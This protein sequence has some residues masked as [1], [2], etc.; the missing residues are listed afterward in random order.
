MPHWRAASYLIAHSST[1][2][3]NNTL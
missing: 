2:Y 1:N 3:F